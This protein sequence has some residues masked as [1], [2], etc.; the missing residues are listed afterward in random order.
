MTEFE[1]VE[2]PPPAA[3]T[4]PKPG[5]ARVDRLAEKPGQW[6]AFH[7]PGP[8][9]A[10]GSAFAVRQQAK[11]RGLKVETA[12]RTNPDGTSTLYARVVES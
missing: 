5:N 11:A 3:K 1:W 9:A 7:F 2:A 4:G 12:S 8:H 10:S 6:G